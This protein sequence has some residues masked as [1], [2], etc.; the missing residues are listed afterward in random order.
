MSQ[1]VD[2]RLCL[3]K[4]AWPPTFQASQNIQNA[5]AQIQQIAHQMQQNAVQ[6]QQWQ[7]AAHQLNQIQ[8]YAGQMQAY[9]AS[10]YGY[11]MQLSNQNAQSMFQP[12]FCEYKCPTS[13]TRYYTGNKPR[14]PNLATGIHRWL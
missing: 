14:I 4:T 5:V 6:T 12:G 11:G 3:P 7:N 2:T 8:N 10:G 13:K 9:P 1:G